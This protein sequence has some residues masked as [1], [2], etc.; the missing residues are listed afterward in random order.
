M[1]WHRGAC[2]L[3]LCSFNMTSS[4]IVSYRVLGCIIFYALYRGAYNIFPD[5]LYITPS[6]IVPIS[7]TVVSLILQHFVLMPCTVVP[8]ILYTLFCGADV[9]YCGASNNTP[10][11][12]V[13]IS[14]SVVPYVM[15]TVLWCKYPLTL[16]YGSNHLY[17]CHMKSKLYCGPS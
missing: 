16:F 10:S 8:N 17:C 5:P 11:T 9:L 4:S 3:L 13:P 7:C 15:H 6:S 12:V 1:T 2:T 14:C